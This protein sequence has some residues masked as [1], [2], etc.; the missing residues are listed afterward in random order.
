MRG[1]FFFDTNVL[2]YVFDKYAGGKR[3][4]CAELVG[5]VMAGQAVGY[6]SNQVLAELSSVLRTKMRHAIPDEEIETVVEL[7][8]SSPKWKKINYTHKT[9]P[10]ALEIARK[11][12]IS[13]WD[14]LIVATM[15]ENGISRI[16]T[17]NRRDFSGVPGIRATDPLR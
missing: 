4:I 12:N 2:A 10:R 15:R 3:K 17:E 16:L 11:L 8:A 13:I 14:A 7:I 1:K 9:I 6:V 5:S